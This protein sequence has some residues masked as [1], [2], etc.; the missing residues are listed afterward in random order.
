MPYFEQDHCGTHVERALIALP[1]LASQPVSGPQCQ[2]FS[3]AAKSRH[4]I[5]A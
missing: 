3:I 4:R 2:V 1:F 5:D